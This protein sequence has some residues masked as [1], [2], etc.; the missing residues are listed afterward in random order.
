MWRLCLCI[1][2]RAWLCPKTDRGEVRVEVWLLGWSVCIF[3]CTGSYFI[4]LIFARKVL[5]RAEVAKVQ[6]FC[7]YVDF[8]GICISLEYLFFWHFWLFLSTFEH[9]YLNFLLVPFSKQTRYFS[10]NVFVF[11]SEL[12]TLRQPKTS[13]WDI[14]GL[15]LNN[16]LVSWC[17]QEQLGQIRLTLPLSLIVFASY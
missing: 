1:V 10:L 11:L 14:L 13:L 5:Q 8:S 16:Q 2:G 7:T 9:K 17:V 6:T 12:R 15:R 3:S 4:C